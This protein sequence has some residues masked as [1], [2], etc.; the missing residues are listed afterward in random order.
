MEVKTGDHKTLLLFF[1]FNNDNNSSKNNNNNDVI[2]KYP[3][4]F[5]HHLTLFYAYKF[6]H[7]DPGCY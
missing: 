7:L 1:M 5:A 6:I 4:I 2:N 3:N